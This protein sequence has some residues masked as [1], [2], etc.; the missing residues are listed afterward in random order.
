MKT[1]NN[2]EKTKYYTQYLMYEYTYIIIVFVGICKQYIDLQ[3]LS[4][5]QWHT[6]SL[7]CYNK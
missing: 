2:F 7:L 4:V 5:I 1:P 6:C 3:W